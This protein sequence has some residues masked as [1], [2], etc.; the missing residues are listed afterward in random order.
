MTSKA[1]CDVR[2][3]TRQPT[4]GIKPSTLR[5]K[6][7]AHPPQ[8]GFCHPLWCWLISVCPRTQRGTEDGVIFKVARKVTPK[9]WAVFAT[10]KRARSNRPLAG[11]PCPR[12]LARAASLRDAPVTKTQIHFAQRLFRKAPNLETHYF[13]HGNVFVGGRTVRKVVLKVRVW[14]THCVCIS[15]SISISR[16]RYRYRYTMRPL[17]KVN[18]YF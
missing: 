3:S 16:S 5:P 18:L 12:C 7:S 8:P 13:S 11:E 6:E 10:D 15:I 2:S 1:A 14:C 4:L 9:L 17:T